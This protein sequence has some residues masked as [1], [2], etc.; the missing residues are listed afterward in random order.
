MDSFNKGEVVTVKCPKTIADG[1]ML[2]HVG[3]LTFPILKKNL[4][5]V[6]EVPDDELRECMRFFGERCKTISEPTG[7][8]GLAGIK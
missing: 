1:A 6:I 2:A 3:Y 7:C 8:L 5:A 4:D